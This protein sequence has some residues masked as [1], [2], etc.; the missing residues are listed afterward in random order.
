MFFSLQLLAARTCLRQLSEVRKRFCSSA[1]TSH[2]LAAGSGQP[3]GTRH[4]KGYC[5]P[6]PQIPSLRCQSRSRS[7]G[8]AAF[9][10][11]LLSRNSRTARRST[12][13]LSPSLGSVQF[14][15]LCSHPSR[16]ITFLLTVWCVCVTDESSKS[17]KCDP[18]RLQRRIPSAAQF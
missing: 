5:T 12:Q 16:G 17:L 2:P 7:C 10:C 15:V 14:H 9:A 13:S 11:H 6:T 3:V 1:I 4:Q 8:P 18:L